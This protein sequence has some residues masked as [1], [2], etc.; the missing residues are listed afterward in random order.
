MNN[1]NAQEK[2][3]GLLERAVVSVGN[4]LAEI[5]I[6]PFQCWAWVLHEPEVTIEIIDEMRKMQ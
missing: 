2:R 5:P 4:K 3:P 6:D 1:M